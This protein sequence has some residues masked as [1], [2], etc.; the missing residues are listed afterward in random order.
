MGLASEEIYHAKIPSQLPRQIR[1]DKRIDLCEFSAHTQELGS[2]KKKKMFEIILNF[3][4]FK[5][6]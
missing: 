2:R 4:P 3:E 5:F 6:G 1:F